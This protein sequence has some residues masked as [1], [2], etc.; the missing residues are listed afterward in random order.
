MELAIV[1]SQL[2]YFISKRQVSGLEQLATRLREKLKIQF[3]SL[4]LSMPIPENAPPEIPRIVLA[5]PNNDQ[6]VQVSLNRVTLLRSYA[7]KNTFEDAMAFLDTY[8]KPIATEL[9]EQGKGIERIGFIIRMF[10]KVEEPLATL[11]R[12]FLLLDFGEL[13]DFGVRFN[14]RRNEGNYEIN[15]LHQYDNGVD[16]DDSIPGIIILRDVNTVAQQGRNFSIKDIE[17]FLDVAKR[18][19]T[20][21]F[22]QWREEK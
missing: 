14:V 20:E 12:K 11:S 16:T 8:W 15:N 4:A 21:E 17:Q 19:A 9:L 1:E 7:K 18:L 6:Q 10:A 5:T 2:V 13:Q 22:D 3:K